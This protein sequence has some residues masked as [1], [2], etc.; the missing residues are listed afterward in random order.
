MPHNRDTGGSRASKTTAN[1]DEGLAQSEV[2]LPCQYVPDLGGERSKTLSQLFHADL[3]NKGLHNLIQGAFSHDLDYIP[4]IEKKKYSISNETGEYI[5]P[6]TWEYFVQ[7]G[8]KIGIEI[9]GYDADTSIG[10]QRASTE[11]P[12]PHVP[13]VPPLGSQN[14]LQ[15]RDTSD[16]GCSFNNVTEE[17][18]DTSSSDVISY[19]ERSDPRFLSIEKVLLEQKQAKVRAEM[20]LECNRRFFRLKQQLVD[21]GATIQARENAADYVEQ[22]SKLAWLE[23]RVREQKE[24]LDRVPPLLVTPPGSSTGE[25]VLSRSTSSPTR[26]AS[27]GARLLDRLPSR[28]N[29]SKDS[30]RM[31]KLIAEG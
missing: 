19:L 4:M 26:K 17:E 2:H 28:S 22:D 7:P 20:K 30:L 18:I 27:L 29:R 15:S 8:L 11:L 14:T 5:L 31:K 6:S 24:E 16:G 25:S 12:P 9:L 10:R 23:K 13:E 1:N 21:Q 3:F